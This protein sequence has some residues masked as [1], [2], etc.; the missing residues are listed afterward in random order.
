MK[1]L[2]G[3]MTSL[4]VKINIFQFG[5]GFKDFL[6]LFHFKRRVNNRPAACDEQNFILLKMDELHLW[7]MYVYGQRQLGIQMLHY[8]TQIFG[9]CKY[10]SPQ[11]S[12]LQQQN[13]TSF[14]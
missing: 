14:S 11:N 9:V 4:E 5:V 13:K 1:K 12:D 7:Y 6:R 8:G 10:L 3:Y 2:A